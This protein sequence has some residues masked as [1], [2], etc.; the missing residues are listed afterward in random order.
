MDCESCCRLW[1]NVGEVCDSIRERERLVAAARTSGRGV[2]YCVIT[3]LQVPV[4]EKCRYKASHYAGFFVT[5]DFVVHCG[6]ES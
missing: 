3:L 2:A 4:D 1:G 5:Y 6:D